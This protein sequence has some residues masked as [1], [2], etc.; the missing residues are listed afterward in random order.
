MEQTDVIVKAR[1]Y[2]LAGNELKAGCLIYDV[3]PNNERPKWAVNVLLLLYPLIPPIDE[4]DEIIKIANTPSRWHEAHVAFYDLRK[5]TLAKFEQSLYYDVVSLAENVAKVTYNA[6]NL[7]AP[8]DYGSGC[9]IARDAKAI[10][11][12]VDDVDLS[13]KVWESLIYPINK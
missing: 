8:F 12:R 3:L 1:E 6:T 10:I 11:N 7:P 5:A 2:W 4:I 9:R 13:T